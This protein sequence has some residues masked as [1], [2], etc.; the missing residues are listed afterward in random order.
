[1]LALEG[2]HVGMWLGLA[3]RLTEWL[4]GLHTRGYIY[5]VKR[6]YIYG[7]GLGFWLTW[8]ARGFQRR[9]GL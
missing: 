8:L 3:V 6:V 9:G 5:I 1:M 7:F 2:T 4:C